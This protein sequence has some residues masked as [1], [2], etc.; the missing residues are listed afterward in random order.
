MAIIKTNTQCTV[1]IS[2]NKKSVFVIDFEM[3]GR[4]TTCLWPNFY[5]DY[6]MS[7]FHSLQEGEQLV[8]KIGGVFAFKVRDGPGGKEATWIVDVKSG[9]GSVSNDPGMYLNEGV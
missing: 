8:K 2:L 4:I 7:L 3:W 1:N 5:K 6:L 9:K